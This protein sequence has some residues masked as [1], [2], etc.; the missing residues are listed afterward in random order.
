MILVLRP[1]A[2]EEQI[3]HIIEK[4]EKPV[5]Q[6]VD[7]TSQAAPAAKEY[8]WAL[9]KGQKKI[10]LDQKEVD[11]F[12]RDVTNIYTQEIVDAVSGTLSDM[13]KPGKY[14]VDR[15]SNALVLVRAE[16]DERVNI[17]FGK[18]YEKDK[19]YYMFVQNDGLIYKVAKSKYDT[20]FKWFDELP[21]KL[22]EKKTE[23]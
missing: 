20:I 22:P 18:E 4:V 13:A 21:K 6:A 10:V 15:M 8:E 17:I 11:K 12:F 9:V 14:G 16:N 5:E 23:T 1:D 3:S 7:D 2:T 19:G